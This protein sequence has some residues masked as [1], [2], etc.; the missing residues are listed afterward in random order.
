MQ[1]T[2]SGILGWLAGVQ[3]PCDDQCF[4][5]QHA[6]KRRRI[7]QDQEDDINTAHAKKH[8]PSPALSPS[9]PEPSESSESSAQ[10]PKRGRQD[11]DSSSANDLFA[12]PRPTYHAYTALESLPSTASRSQGSPL[13][14]SRTS[15]PTKQM[16]AA[17][18]EDTGFKHQKFALCRN[19][20]PPSLSQLISSTRPDR[21]INHSAWGN[22]V[23]DPIALSIETK[24]HDGDMTK[25]TLQMGIWLSS[26]W[27]NLRELASGTE[28]SWSCARSFMRMSGLWGFQS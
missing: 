10:A 14:R 17:E 22:F 5:D 19:S 12:T 6:R 3:P 1:Q 15:S 11:G 7:T 20:L 25:S 21:S 4:V 2:Q 13:T 18:Q 8:P 28:S 9:R 26:Q 16:R 23:R 27:R 24:C